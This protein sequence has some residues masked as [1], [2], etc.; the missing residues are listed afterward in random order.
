MKWFKI[1]CFISAYI[2]IK[3]L[4]FPVLIDF[5]RKRLFFLQG[6]FLHLSN[7]FHHPFRNIHQIQLPDIKKYQ[8]QNNQK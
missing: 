4:F 6:N 3:H 5:N 1:H 7:L 2:K 8:N